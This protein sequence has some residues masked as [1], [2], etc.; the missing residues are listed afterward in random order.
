MKQ[1]R[2]IILVLSVVIASGAL[3]GSSAAA[4][5][6]KP[7][8]A[9]WLE[10]PR[11]IFKKYGLFSVYLFVTNKGDDTVRVPFASEMLRLSLTLKMVNS[12]GEELRAGALSH[13][14]DHDSAALATGDTVMFT[15]TPLECFHKG[16]ARE[17]QPLYIPVGRYELSGV[18]WSEYDLEPIRLVVVEL[19]DDEEEMV[20]EYYG[21]VSR[22]SHGLERVADFAELLDKYHN[23][24]LGTRVAQALLG[25]AASARAP[26]EER[27]VY[28]R[29]IIREFPN[30]GVLTWALG[31]LYAVMDDSTLVRTLQDH[32][33]LSTHKYS[34]FMLKEISRQN[35]RMN[36][37]REVMG[38]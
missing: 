16:G 26:Q 11:S 18:Y 35:G 10:T 22:Y 13:P 20:K 1:M 36:V 8:L 17:Q 37:Y 27:V 38:E 24:F 23:T 7:E 6:G 30:C 14:I 12:Q 19:T 34:R 2:I 4:S 25:A 5:D 29:S 33:E 32:P 3:P 28:A 21:T 9:A 31:Y 15:L